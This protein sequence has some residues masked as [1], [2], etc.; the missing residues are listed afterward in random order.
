MPRDA[1]ASRWLARYSGPPNS[2]SA[3]YAA[4]PAVMTNLLNRS[5]WALDP[6]VLHLNHGSYG[7]VPKLVSAEQDRW[8]DVVE[9]NPTGFFSRRLAERLEVVRTR[10]AGFMH[11]DPLGLVLQPNVTWAV[12]TVMA[13]VPLERGDE[14][15]ITDDTYQGVQIAARDACARTGA[16]LIKASLSSSAFGDGRQVADAIEERLSSHTKLAVIDHIT[17]PTAA[18]VDPAQTMD[19]CHE[20]GT[21]VLVDG[22]HAPGMLGLDVGR[23][24]ADFYAGN[25]HKWCC[26]PRGA[27]FLA[28]AP[29]WRRRLRS[30]VPGSEA[31]QGFPCGFEWWGTMEYSALLATP[32]ALDLLEEIGVD[33]LRERNAQLVNNG[34]AIVSRALDQ[35]PPTASTLSMV[36]LALPQRM[37]S[38]AVSGRALRQRIAAE[39]RAEVMITAARGRS[40]LRLS[41]QAY[42]REDDYE[43]LADYLAAL[44]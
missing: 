24:G 42:N 2:D 34:A 21:V 37:S 39:L 30:P 36:A 29:E 28:V 1:L 23:L 25:F 3:A 20:N 9:S 8:R 16:Q 27:A 10:A 33:S 15:L 14:V 41:A 26:A 32:T 12:S 44:G 43:R 7:A 38:D 19:R 13:S 40:V 4:I 35:D 5:E 11:A 17:S 18:L 22:A 31:D 6:D